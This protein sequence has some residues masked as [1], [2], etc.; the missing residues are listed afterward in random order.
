[1]LRPGGSL[2]LEVGDGQAFAV[3]GLAREAGFAVTAAHKDLS[4]KDRIV[5]ATKAG[6][7]TLSLAGAV[8]TDLAAIGVA[9]EAGAIIGI[10][11]D[12]VYGL[13]ARWDSARGVRRL[14]AAKGRSP[15]Q[16][17]AALFPSVESVVRAL[18]DLEP[19]A[20]KILAALL[21]GP[22]TF[23]VSTGVSR[24]AMVGT[25]DSL[26]VRVPDHP[27]LLGLMCALGS[28]LAAT[29][30]NRTCEKDPADVT[31][32]DAFL[33]GHCSAVFA[34]PEGERAT[35]SASTVV[36]LRPLS[37]GGSPVVLREGA[38]SGPAVLER[39]AAL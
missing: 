21:P 18:P 1:V 8:E 32:V 29:S 2:L 39:I 6:A 33:A 26:G 38:V 19:A 14:F 30:A 34:A 9:L 3:Q 28:P 16:P 5:E 12:T 23:I 36:D 35:G 37:G 7:V 31:E 11:T 27:G 10:P 20:G 25:E 17:V 24:P 15:E 4:G 22:F 13:A